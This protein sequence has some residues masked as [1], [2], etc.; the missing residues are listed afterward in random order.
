MVCLTQEFINVEFDFTAPSEI[1][2][3]ALKRLFQ[4]LFY[5]HAPTM[6]L[7]VVADYVV[8]LSQNHGIGTVVK[9][10]DMEQ[11]RDPYAVISA[12]TFGEKGVPAADLLRTYLTTQL[13]RSAKGK[14]LLDLINSASGSKPLVLLL[15]ERMINLPAQVMPPLLRMLHEEYEEGRQEAT[16]PAAEPTHLLVFSRGF[17]A[18]ALE[19]DADQEPTGLAGARKRKAGLN[20]THP[21]DAAAAALGK[22][23]KRKMIKTP[24]ASSRLDDG[25]GSFHPEDELLAEFVSHHFHFRFPPP[26][27]AIDTY[28][29]PIY[30]RIMAIPY[31]KVPAALARIQAEWPAPM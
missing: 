14:P 8:N 3:Q 19:E 5:T 27:D 15:H 25:L 20:Q 4:Q 21:D 2:Y 16:P 22:A 1:D 29:A 30:G 11:V 23:A 17:S 10:D 7:G 13:A 24:S 9:V 28:E 26:R 6:D 12:L 18:D 31:A